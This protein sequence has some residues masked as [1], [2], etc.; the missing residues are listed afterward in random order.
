MSDIGVV[1]LIRRHNRLEPFERFL[2]SYQ[3]FPAGV[4]HDLVLVF[5]G[6]AFGRGT[7]D[8]DKLLAGVP[9]RRIYLADYGFDLGPYF[10]VVRKFEYRYFCFFNSFSRIL[11]D[12]WLAKFHRWI[13]AEGVG[14]V[15]ATGSYESF[16]D[17]YLERT[18]MLDGMDSLARLKFEISHLTS[19]LRPAIFARRTMGWIISGL[20]IR[21][22]RSG[23]PPFP[24]YH[25][26]TNAFMASRQTLLRIRVGRMFLKMSAYALESSRDSLTNQV[27]RLGLKSLVVNRSGEAFEMERWHLSDTFRQ[28][29]QQ[30]LL[31]SDTQTEAYA[32]A[33]GESR[34]LMS[35]RTW[36]QFARPA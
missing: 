8:Y 23:F 21:D 24:N 29:L 17:N 25:I 9:H 16:A 5:K 11:A 10:R 2:D 28:S 27:M 3:R 18:R 13:T 7:R 32:S 34:S 36:R 35:R 20:G 31:V 15:G 14:L 12:D 30:D 1:H 26:R 19:D 22:P 4:P 33:D 6:F